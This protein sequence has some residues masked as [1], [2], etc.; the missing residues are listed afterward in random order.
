MIPVCQRQIM[1]LQPGV[2]LA[3]FQKLSLKA[4]C[5][6]VPYSSSLY[7]FPQLSRPISQI[8]PQKSTQLP[9]PPMESMCCM[10]G[11]RVCVWDRYIDELEAFEV[12]SGRL[13]SGVRD[14]ESDKSNSTEASVSTVTETPSESHVD[15]ALESANRDDVSV[16]VS[17]FVNFEVQQR[18]KAALQRTTRQRLKASVAG[19]HP[20]IAPRVSRFINIEKDKSNRMNKAM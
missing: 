17:A 18:K 7:K 12:G 10:S 9:V 4:T 16:Y 2:I 1:P 8:A 14:A 6:A 15:K 3:R 13:D 11:C 20:A 19:T 5:R